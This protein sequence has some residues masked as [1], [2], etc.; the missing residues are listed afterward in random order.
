MMK[1]IQLSCKLLHSC[2]LLGTGT[3]AT[4]LRTGLVE[5]PRQVETEGG[6]GRI[7]GCELTDAIDNGIGLV[8]TEKVVAAQVGCQGSEDAETVV[9]LQTQTGLKAGGDHAEVVVVALRGPLG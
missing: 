9:A 1:K 2:F 3:A 6:T 7:H 4:I 5:L 8:R